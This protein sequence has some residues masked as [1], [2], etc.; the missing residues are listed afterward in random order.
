ML[1]RVGSLMSR[2]AR[3]V[4]A[5]LGLKTEGGDALTTEAGDPLA[6]ES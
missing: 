2:A 3:G 5:A 1:A 6:P 4:A